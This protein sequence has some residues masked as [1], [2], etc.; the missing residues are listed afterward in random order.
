MKEAPYSLDAEQSV[1]GAL[2]LNPAA[3]DD[4][5]DV[6]GAGDFYSAPNR[7]I[8]EA[9][10]D[11]QA[12]RQPADFTTL[13]DYLRNRKAVDDAG[14]IA[15]LSSLAND[16]P[17]AANVM[18]YARL[19]RDYSTRRQMIQAGSGICDLAYSPGEKTV[20]EIV[21]EA[22]KLAMR[23]GEKTDPSAP[24]SIGVLA[25]RFFKSLEERMESGI[26]GVSTGL[27]A[28]DNKL[29]GLQP[30]DL[31]I[32]A[33]RPSM[34]KTAI[35]IGVA[36]WVSR[37]KNVAIFSME[38]SKDQVTGRLVSMNSGVPISLMRTPREMSGQ[39]HEAVTEGVKKVRQRHIIV[40]DRG[41]LTVLQLGAKARR[42]HRRRPLSLIVVDYL[43]LMTGKGGNRNDEISEISRGLKALAKELKCP[44]IALSQLNRG[45]EQR[46][47]KRP[48]MSDLRDSGAI[49]QDADVVIGMYRDEYYDEGSPH[50][51]IAEAII[52]KQR[53]GATGTVEL[54]WVG[55][56]CLFQN[57]TGPSASERQPKEEPKGRG[58]GTPKT[59]P[60]RPWT[61]AA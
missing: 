14:G 15:Y 52:L 1:L 31:L 22:Q 10:V 13:V 56:L 29:G 20:P 46:D 7:L 28:L 55:E 33:G 51:G 19:V 23:L 3:L 21:D 39:H 12:S 49:E 42:I 16:T 57:Y 44:V 40:D 2:L 50:K 25:E 30:D 53:N 17:S 34:G 18:A 26:V 6:L 38:M 43:Q 27:D 60:V 48:R 4:L 8:F 54:Q 35:A 24:E 45:C 11:L 47:N 5:A 58:F 61:E 36:D 9:L 59:A 32:I 41:G 37:E